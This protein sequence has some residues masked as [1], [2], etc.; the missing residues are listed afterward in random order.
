V[1][2]VENLRKKWY[3]GVEH[4]NVADINMLWMRTAHVTETLFLRKAASQP[5]H[6]AAGLQAT[7]YLKI[8]GGVT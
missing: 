3:T 4:I 1:Y 6:G 7:P 8:L 5:A 2:A